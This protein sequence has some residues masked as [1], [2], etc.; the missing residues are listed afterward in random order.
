MRSFFL[1]E[2]HN[3]FLYQCY[4]VVYHNSRTNRTVFVDTWHST[5][6]AVCNMDFKCTFD[7]QYKISLDDYLKQLKNSNLIVTPLPCLPYPG[8]LQDYPELFI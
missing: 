7:T 8:M 1:L 4:A 6:Q 2:D 3:D 5:I